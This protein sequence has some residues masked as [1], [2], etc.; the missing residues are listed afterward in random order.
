VY[1]FDTINDSEYKYESIQDYYPL[2]ELVEESD[3]ID[4]IEYYLSDIEQ[5]QRDWE[6]DD[7]WMFL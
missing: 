7:G 3:P 4:P 1:S 2:E 5:E 6:E